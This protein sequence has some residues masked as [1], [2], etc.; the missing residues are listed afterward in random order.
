[1][2]NDSFTTEERMTLAE[3]VH[4]SFNSLMNL[5]VEVAANDDKHCD[6]L[7]KLWKAHEVMANEMTQMYETMQEIL[8]GGLTQTDGVK[9]FIDDEAEEVEED[10]DDV[11]YVGETKKRPRDSD[12]AEEDDEVVFVGETKKPRTA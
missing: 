11:V 10:D 9:R 1:M 3:R 4:Y 8:E 5:K 7:N 6:E 2:S 12:G